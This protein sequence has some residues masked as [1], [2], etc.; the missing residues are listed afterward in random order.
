MKFSEVDEGLKQ[1]KKYLEKLFKLLSQNNISSTLVIYPWPTQILYGDEYHQNLWKE[2]ASSQ[3]IN[4]LSMYEYFDDLDKK[5]FI[6]EN[7]I[8]G[9]I[10]W[11]KK[12][13][14][15]I[16]NNLIKNLKF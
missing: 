12:G 11:N 7:F 3:Q 8:F 4:F 2:F 15:I 5:K 14:K 16:F 9:D 13:T 1:S 10:H 6:F